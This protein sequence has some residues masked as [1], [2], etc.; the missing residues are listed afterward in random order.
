MK[1]NKFFAFKKPEV[2]RVALPLEDG[3]V[4]LGE[5]VVA[6]KVG[7]VLILGPDDEPVD[8]APDGELWRRDHLISTVDPFAPPETDNTKPEPTPEKAKAGKKKKKG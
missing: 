1:V 4:K 5:N 2:L 7:D 8:V 3:T 6:V